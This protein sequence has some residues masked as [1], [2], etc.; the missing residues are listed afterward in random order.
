MSLNLKGKKKMKRPYKS[1]TK[2]EEENIINNVIG[3]R[4]KNARLK[5]GL[6]QTK[7]ANQLKVSFQQVG[8]Y[9]K[10]DNGLSAIRI[11]KISNILN[12]PKTYLLDDIE[13]LEKVRPTNNNSETC[14]TESNQS[15]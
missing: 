3:S 12:I 11:I 14:C 4:L 10:G 7:L 1:Y 13:L 8:K 6:T 5:A 9:E 15:V 2:T